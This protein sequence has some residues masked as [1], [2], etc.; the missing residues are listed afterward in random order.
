M[1]TVAQGG[2]TRPVQNQR[3]RVANVEHEIADGAGLLVATIETPPIAGAAGASDGGQRPIEYPDD[4]A[5]GNLFGW[6]RQVITAA[7][8]F[9]AGQD[10]GVFQLKQDGVEKFAW[11]LIGCSHL[12][13]Q[14]GPLETCQ[15]D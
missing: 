15:M 4:L 12:H 9:L 14:T 6:T 5:G 2:D 13:G 8:T 11:N 1:T 7:L 3:D 10:T